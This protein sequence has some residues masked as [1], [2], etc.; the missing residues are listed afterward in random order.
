[1]T[2][3]VRRLPFHWRNFAWEALSKRTGPCGARRKTQIS[4]ERGVQGW[5]AAGL[6]N[7]QI[8]DLRKMIPH[9]RVL[10]PEPLL[11]LPL[12]CFCRVAH[13]RAITATQNSPRGSTFSVDYETNARRDSGMMTREMAIC[14]LG[15][16]LPYAREDSAAKI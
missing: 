13:P 7:P 12:P 4:R 8:A 10:R 16:K 1:M 5:M 9:L 11:E 15:L 3:A 14:L 2:R 6:G